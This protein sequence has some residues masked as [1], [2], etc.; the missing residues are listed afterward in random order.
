MATTTPDIGSQWKAL[1]PQ[2]RDVALSRMTPEQKTKLATTLGYKAP[3]VPTPAPADTRNGF[4][5]TV[6]NWSQPGGVLASNTNPNRGYMDDVAN[7]ANRGAGFVASMVAHPVKAAEGTVA[8][9]NEV[10]NMEEPQFHG[11]ITQRIKEFRD[12]YSKDPRLAVDNL[13]G[14]L[15]G[16]YATGKV[17]G[18]ATDLVKGTVGA[19]ADR[20]GN[21]G[22]KYAPRTVDVGGTKVP[23]TVGEADPESAAGRTQS[24]LK[25]GGA[26][27]DRF[28]KVEKAQQQAVKNVIRTTAQ[29]TSGAI[30]PMQVEP[31]DVV[32]DA[33]TA[34]YVKAAPLYNELDSALVK[35]P[36]AL[37]KVSKITQDAIAKARKLGVDV[38]DD[39]VDLTK[40]RPRKDGTIQ[41]GGSQISKATHPEIWDKLVKD[42]VIDDAGGATPLKAYRMVRSQLLKMQRASSDPAVRFAIGKDIDSMTSNIDTALKGT[43]VEKNWSAA[44][45][46]WSKGKALQDVSEAVRDAT[47]GTPS[48][49]Q[50]P[51]IAAV[52][53][54]LRGALLV[55][56]LNELYKDGTL[57]RAFSHDEISNLRQSADILDR[58]QRTPVGSGSGE[59]LSFS[60]GLTH[61][62]RG[63]AAP[64]IGAA[65]GAIVGGIRGAEMGAGMGF[66]L[67]KIGEQGLIRVMTKL[68][69]VK[70]LES[71]EDAKTPSETSAATEKII[72]LGSAGSTAKGP[73][74]QALQQ[75]RDHGRYAHVAVGPNGHR[76]GSNDGQTWVDTETGDHVQ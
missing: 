5:Q 60:R 38:G 73:K 69:G 31:S 61:A 25:R 28:K 36:D 58:I 29:K 13:A 12:E 62:V 35:V 56:K 32:N 33:A 39:S 8:M 66:I 18:G 75:A 41:W 76:I 26:G 19:V 44:N 50:A 74:T 67:Q 27:E 42:G 53:T 52:P 72:S 68:D 4:Q 17:V 10:T 45:K 30:G 2:Q 14:D 9:L 54:K 16:M 49:A 15:V 59:T 6:D 64:L 7:V 37:D 65:G 24:N 46:L 70:A 11:P 23:V 55:S 1:N 57:E 34:S 22:S 51:G 63:N 40:I 71:L 43:D 48:T 3:A 21:I 47:K 20:A